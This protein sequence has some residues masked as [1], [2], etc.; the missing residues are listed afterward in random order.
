[1]NITVKKAEVPACCGNC[2]FNDWQEDGPMCVHPAHWETDQFELDEG[3]T[4]FYCGE[5]ATEQGEIDWDDVCEHHQRG[6]NAILPEDVINALI[7]QRHA[8]AAAVLK[9]QTPAAS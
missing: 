3:G 5:R 4:V 9:A 6:N 8:E 2:R 7:D 1:M